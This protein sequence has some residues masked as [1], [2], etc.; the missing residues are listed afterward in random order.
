MFAVA[1]TVAYRDPPRTFPGIVV[2]ALWGPNRLVAMLWAYFDDSGLHKAGTDKLDWLVLG[3][4][5][6]AENSEHVLAEW[7]AALNDFG[8]SPHFNGRF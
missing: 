4:M 8:V 3:G 1:E 5:A 7:E 2:R 6:P